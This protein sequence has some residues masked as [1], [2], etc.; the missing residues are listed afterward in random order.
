MNNNRETVLK[1]LQEHKQ[2]VSELMEKIAS[3][4]I[5][6]GL[7]HDDSKFNSPE[8]EA[9]TEIRN[10]KFGTPEYLAVCNSEGIKHHYKVNRHHPEHFGV[11]KV[12]I[13]NLVDL[14]EY[15]ADCYV[16]AKR[17]SGCMVDF[18]KNKERHGI[19]DQLLGILT[20]TAEYL[21]R[22]LVEI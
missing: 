2:D 3:E 11:G 18:S 12:N 1:E 21:D 17:R 22:G 8:I 19:E 14:I 10:M 4:L 15:V 16:A 20:E 7:T 13:M 9:L 6:R 5:R